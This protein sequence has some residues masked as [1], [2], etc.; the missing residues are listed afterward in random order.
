M[1]CLDYSIRLGRV[2]CGV[3]VWNDWVRDVFEG[4]E[5]LTFIQRV[6]DRFIECHLLAFFKRGC[7]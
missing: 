7:K 3:V 5:R 1:T 2:G 4:E 6:R